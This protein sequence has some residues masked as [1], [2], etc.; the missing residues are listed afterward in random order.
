MRQALRLTLALSLLYLLLAACAVP[1]LDAPPERIHQNSSLHT[2]FDPPSFRPAYLAYGIWQRFDTLWYRQIAEQGYW[3]PATVVF[4]PLLPLAIRLLT[5]LGIP[6]PA[7]AVLASR[8]ALF[9]AIWGLLALLRLD[10]NEKELTRALALFFAWP[11]S[12]ILFGGYAEPF[13][14]AATLWCVYFARQG[15]WWPAA[16]CALL[17]CLSRA[18]GM[19][20]LAPLFWLAWRQRPFRYAPLVL[21]LLGP[22]LFPLFLKLN[23]LPTSSQAYPVYWKTTMALPWQTV[24]DVFARLSADNSFFIGINAAA[25]VLVFLPALAY[26]VRTEYFWYALGTL[27]FLFTAKADPPLHSMVRYV[28]PVF[29]AFASAARLLKNQTLMALVWSALALANALLLYSFW[30]WYFLI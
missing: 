3:R 9:F 19:V 21:A 6:S 1:L 18:A 28:L 24:A 29:P 23:G 14:L 13:L 22:F 8:L 11:M 27:C 10:L 5:T 16:L 20:V 26:A 2:G 4:Y 12:F 7:A 15:R 25:L 17:A 30:D